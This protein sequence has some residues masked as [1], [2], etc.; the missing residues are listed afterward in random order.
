MIINRIHTLLLAAAFLLLGGLAAPASAQVTAKDSAAVLQTW[1]MLDYMA[2]DYPGAVKDGTVIDASEYKEMQEFAAT[3][4][5]RID[6]LTPTAATPDL[7]A[8]AASLVAAIHAKASS[9]E[10][11]TKAHAVTKALLAAY[12]V[13]TTPTTA[14]DLATGARL[15]QSTCAACHGATGH[16]DGPAGA[17]LTP[18]PIDFT[19][20]ARA[21]QRS[22]LSLFETLS[23]GVEGTSMASYKDT[24]NEQ[25]RWDLAYYVG[26]LAYATDAAAGQTA[27]H[28][29]A[30]ARAQ[31]AGLKELTHARASELGASLGVTKARDILGH[32]RAHP[33][34]VAE[35]PTGLALARGR[36]AASLAAYRHGKPASATRLALSAYLDGVEPVEAQLDIR[37]RPLRSKIEL[38]MGAYRTAL[39][40][41]ASTDQVTAEAGRV[42]ALLAKAQDAV[43]AGSSNATAVFL[44]AFTILVREGLEA[45][46]VVVALLACLRKA[47]RADGARYVHIG[48]IAA[49]AAGI[50]TWFVARY[51]IAISGASRELTEGLSSIF[52]A[53]VLLG[54]GLWMHQKSIGGRWQAY[55][56]AKMNEAMGRGS[57]WF[58]FALAFIT[59]YREIFE[60]ILFYTALW[61][62]GQQ[63]WMLAG[64][65][66]G[67]VVLAVVAWV[68]LRTSRRLPLGAF[69]KASSAL[70]AILAVVLAGK[71]VAALQEA[72][73]VG[74][75]LAPVPHID[76]LGIFPSWQPVLAQLIVVLLLVAGFAFNNVRD[77]RT[78]LARAH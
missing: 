40:N 4:A 13:P 76:I 17:A 70:I 34:A 10:V 61:N 2:A 73:W 58:L 8:K 39:K 29:D 5:R 28:D 71:G 63:H 32:L 21:D 18:P 56:K 30:T 37:N 65:A 7:N 72:G 33:Q 36:L 78:A 64:I 1:Q 60:T 6:A 22:V 27:W 24:F 74:V 41:G 47:E 54:V 38:T 31:L 46:L 49:I 66:A 51:A 43:N 55:I 59:V 23:Q 50:G 14:P 62:E 19:D 15:Y 12:P 25:Q 53:V 68:M 75:T 3:A 11:A 52:A 48:W 67:A 77:K 16:G 42:D 35:A 44:G 57:L 9:D 69:F 45:L 20:T 26:S